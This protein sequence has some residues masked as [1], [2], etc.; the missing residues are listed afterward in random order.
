MLSQKQLVEIE[1]QHKK[2][3]VYR[4]NLPPGSWLYDSFAFV[5]NRDDFMTGPR[6]G[7]EDRVCILVRRR[8]WID[9]LMKAC[10][11]DILDEGTTARS[12]DKALQPAHVAQYI[13]LFM[14]GSVED[15]IERLI[16]EV[17]RL[18]GLQPS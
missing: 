2:R 10:G 9:A 16:D 17:R 18:R 4:A 12:N 8:T 15:H 14:N 1:E 3:K 5:E 7:L 6:V 11:D 13:E